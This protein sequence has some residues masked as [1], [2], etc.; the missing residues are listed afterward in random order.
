[1]LYR[2]RN[3]QPK[4]GVDTYIDEH[5]LLIG[6]VTI[7]DN[8]YVGPGAII[9]GD[10]GTI[11]IGS[12]TA[13][14]EGVI[15]HAPP[16][17]ICRIGGKVT[18]AHGAIIHSTKIADFVVVGMGAVVSVYAEVGEETIIAEG[19]IVRMRQKIPAGVVVSGNPAK[20][21]GK[22]TQ[23]QRE[24]WEWGKGVYVDLAREYVRNGLQKIE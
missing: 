2:F 8:C 18:L 22:I 14:E 16:G 4:F 9:R 24:Y 10:Y 23:K 17:D 19:S 6:D 5:A 20:V 3:K 13:V 21:V 11:E 1:M 7:G 12:G 15:I